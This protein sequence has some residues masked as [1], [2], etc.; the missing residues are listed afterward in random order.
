L[1]VPS[2]RRPLKSVKG[3]TDL[4]TARNET[5]VAEYA[6]SS[7]A[8]VRYDVKKTRRQDEDLGVVAWPATYQYS[9]VP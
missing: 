8:A 6:A 2:L 4:F 9:R 3:R 7:V 1:Y 5:N